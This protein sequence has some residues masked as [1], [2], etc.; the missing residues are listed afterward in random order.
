MPDERAIS[1]G[2]LAAA[3]GTKVETIR[4]YERIGLLPTPER[5]AG[6]Q[7]LYGEAA[8]RRL[9]FL[10]HARD[11]GFSLAAIRELLR[12]T[13]QPDQPCAAIDRIARSHL[14]SVR[15]RLAQLRSLEA[16]LERMVEQC[17]GGAV[18]ECRVIESLADH[19]HCLAASHR[20]GPADDPT[21]PPAGE[22][23]GK[24]AD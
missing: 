24:E 16:E 3:T 1:I 22:E 13:D 12:L 2:R 15:R 23:D 11:L 6:N 14:T 9:S 8:R 5:N 18:A 21:D 17:R 19:R 7:R 20:D 10:R 4:Y